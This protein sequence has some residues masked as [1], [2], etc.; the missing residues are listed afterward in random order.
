MV[1][2]HLRGE[3]EEE[4]EAVWRRQHAELDLPVSMDLAHPVGFHHVVTSP[5]G[6]PSGGS[7]L[8]LLRPL[9]AP[10]DR[11]VGRRLRPLRPED[12]LMWRLQLPRQ[13][14]LID[15]P[16]AEGLPRL[17]LAVV[18]VRRHH[19]PARLHPLL[20]Q[21]A[22]RRRPHPR[23]RRLLRG[24]CRLWPRTVPKASSW[25]ILGPMAALCG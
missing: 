18:A 19:G 21:W 23:R 5:P 14:E 12:R 9:E 6:S 13:G 16:L 15:R 2:T 4:E 3:E 25:A 7:Q 10:W 1:L 11:S 20:R 8:R 17:R 24:P 22:L